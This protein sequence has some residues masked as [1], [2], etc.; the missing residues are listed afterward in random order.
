[1]R[2]SSLHARLLRTLILA[3][4]IPLAALAAALHFQAVR[5]EEQAMQ[6]LEESAAKLASGI[7]SRLVS[8][9]ESLEAAAV[10]VSPMLDLS[11]GR[12]AAERTSASQL[13]YIAAGRHIDT[14]V[15]SRDGSLLAYGLSLDESRAQTFAREAAE[16]WVFRQALR[17]GRSTQSGPAAGEADSSRLHLAVPVASQGPNRRINSVIIARVD[18]PSVFFQATTGFSPEMTARLSDRSGRTVSVI[19]DANER[20]VIEVSSPLSF[21]DM[22]LSVAVPK[23]SLLQ[24]VYWLTLVGAALV[25]AIAGIC[26]RLAR[27]HL[28]NLTA[29]FQKLED[30]IGRL[31]RGDLTLDHDD[32]FTGVQEAESILS[33]FRDMAASLARS[34][35]EIHRINAELE[36]RVRVRTDQL[37]RQNQEL[38]DINRLLV[39]IGHSRD[40][41]QDEDFRDALESLRIH[42]GLESL[43]IVA[44]NDGQIPDS[45]LIHRIVIDEHGSL[46]A[47]GASSIRPD[48]LRTLERFARFLKVVRE[49]LRLLDETK[50]QHAALSA[51]FGA[52]SE[53]FALIAP[54]GAHLLFS[55]DRL[56]ECLRLAGDGVSSESFLGLAETDERISAIREALRV[57]EQDHIWQMVRDGELLKVLCVRSFPVTI[58]SAASGT[59]EARAL[60]LRDVTHEFEV[61]KLKDDVLALTSHE[62]NNP[63][64]AIRLGLETLATKGDRLNEKTRSMLFGHL[65]SESTRLQNL[66]RD[67]LDI[68]MLNHGSLTYRKNRIDFAELVK[69]TAGFWA[70]GRTSGLAI[71]TPDAPAPVFADPDR[72]RQVILNLLENAA[73][74]ND[75]TDPV[76]DVSV[77][78]N[79][80]FC[81]LRVADNGMGM[82]ASDLSRVFEQFYRGPRAVRKSPNGSGLGLSICRSVIEAH[83]GS[84]EVERTE[85]GSGTTMLV[86][87]PCLK[88]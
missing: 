13:L 87:L 79:N 73:R 4:V 88:D 10:A 40:E 68:S 14:V 60:L 3:A 65:M 62:L 28:R 76:I 53:G 36:E 20:D 29:F 44:P 1:M 82:T 41:T 2:S 81:E 50:R 18:L 66:L 86:R 85:V 67:W 61:S 26:Y 78:M 70:E 46:E 51:V 52:M 30:Y 12:T 55:N 32:G 8:V 24:N 27:L 75:K 71:R 16:S 74:Y 59:V 31:R 63:V 45:S 37:R 22:T 69:D 72:I 33:K 43:R 23:A 58:P 77:T 25:L 47:C 54:D 6:T 49:N 5:L 21:S 9:L 48:A 39:P 19:G 35:A 34:D 42:L 15:V 57:P 84:L 64:A 11:D 83:D 38:A 80:G 7:E 56:D 17:S